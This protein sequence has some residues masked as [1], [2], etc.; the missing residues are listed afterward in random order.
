MIITRT[1]FRLSFFG[2]GT[3]F[4]DFFRE[5]GG[6]VLSTTINH[7]CYITC[8]IL[9]PF[10]EYNYSLRYS[11][12]E[13]CKAVDEI[14]HTIVR[15]SLKHLAFHPG[16]EVSH[17][18]DLP[19]NSGIG[20]SSAFAV[21]F[22]NA[23]HGLS[24]RMMTKR[25]IAKQAIYIEREMLK[26]NVGMQD[27]IAT[28]FGGFNRIDFFE[29]NKFLV[30]PMIISGNRLD[31][32]NNSLIMVYT[33]IFRVSSEIAAHAVFNAKKNVLAL[34][35]MKAQVDEAINILAGTES[36][37]RFGEL[38]DE[39]WLLKRSLSNKVSNSAI[40]TMY[41]RA[42]KSGALGGKICGAGGG[43]F[44]LFYVPQDR[45]KR[46]L[47]EFKESIHVPFRFEN[48]GSQVVFFTANEPYLAKVGE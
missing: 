43:G 6:S 40:D 36:V 17:S 31:Y 33:N 45:R 15:E 7:Y 46:F 28:S 47:E 42:K 38:L 4:P 2:G 20:S 18:G 14:Q 19:A 11:I 16:I 32:L 30:T 24:S 10:F 9:P 41:E 35:E 23:L 34:K 3:D 1:P 29:S 12:T 26:D 44:F 25:E 5:H 39:A 13:R 8:R 27:Q 21:G 37:D 48:Y 22:L